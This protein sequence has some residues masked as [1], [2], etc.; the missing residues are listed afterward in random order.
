[1]TVL[2]ILTPPGQSALATLALAGENAWSAVRA[3]FNREL[4]AT[5]EPGQT[6]LGKLG[7][8]V[9]DEVVLACKTAGPQQLVEIHCHGGREVV[10]FLVELFLDQGITEVSWQEFLLRTQPT[11]QAQAGGALAQATT[12]RVAAI[13]LDQYRGAF[14]SALRRVD[15]HLGHCEP[16]PALEGLR[17]LAR[18]A[19]LGRKLVA[20]FRVVLAGPPNVGKSSLANAL[21]GYQRSIVAATPGTTRDVV[22]AH[23]ALDGWPVE[24]SDTAGLREAPGSLEQEGI[25]RTRATLADADLVVWLMD[26]ADP[27]P[28]SPDR[29][30]T[31]VV[32]NK[33]D[34]PA[35]WLIPGGTLTVSALSGQGLD[36][37]IAAIVARL[38]LEVPPAGTAIPFTPDLAD[39]VERMVAALETGRHDEVRGRLKDLLGG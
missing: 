26:A 33:I 37:L 14:E 35:T 27:A 29:P 2:A 32:V 28:V 1:V 16:R 24:L 22:S 6:W 19:P 18:W 25:S 13:L 8:E 3:H 39:T 21:A 38:V 9:A 20:G 12:P 15:S 10:R 31:L 23:L 11:L 5:P 7:R 30:D 36:A 34:L 17:A 4:P